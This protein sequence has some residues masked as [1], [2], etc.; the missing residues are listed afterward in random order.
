MEIEEYSPWFREY[1]PGSGYNNMGIEN[2]LLDIEEC[3]V[4]ILE[5]AW[6]IV[7]RIF[8]M[9]YSTLMKEKRILGFGYRILGNVGST[10]ANMACVFTDW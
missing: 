3:I 4:E 10:M 8:K 7:K 2:S 9:K 6:G 1:N 5:F